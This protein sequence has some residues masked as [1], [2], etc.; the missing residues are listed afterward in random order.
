MKRFLIPLILL[1]LGG[2]C[3]AAFNLIGSKVM[4]DGLLVEP[5]FLVPIGSLLIIAGMVWGITALIIGAVK[6][7]KAKKAKK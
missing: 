3:V 6:A 5:F 4:P 1:I 7:G 2:G